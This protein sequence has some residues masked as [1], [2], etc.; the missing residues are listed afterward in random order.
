MGR[1]IGKKRVVMDVVVMIFKVPFIAQWDSSYYT[2]N[3]DISL[4][5]MK[6]LKIVI[7]RCSYSTGIV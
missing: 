4:N 5:I 7:L 1:I 6:I 3:F 2:R